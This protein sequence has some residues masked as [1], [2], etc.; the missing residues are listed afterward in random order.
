MRQSNWLL[1][2]WI[3]LALIGVS[4][5]TTPLVDVDLSV[6]GEKTAL[7]KQVLGSY[8]ALGEDLLIYSSVRGV[9]EDGSLKLPPPATPSQQAA[10]GALHDREYNRDDVERMLRTGVVGE[11]NTGMLVVRDES[12]LREV[13]R[14]SREQ[15]LALIREENGSRETILNRLVETTTGLDGSQQ[16]EIVRIFAELNRDTAPIGAWVQNTVGTWEQR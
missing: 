6:V 15:V 13:D 9:D 1:W 2:H 3:L 5:C 14:L 7:E 8:H 16:S 12:K 10:F 11:A 4:G